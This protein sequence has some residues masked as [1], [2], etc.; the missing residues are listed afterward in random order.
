[1]KHFFKVSNLTLCIDNHQENLDENISLLSS[2]YI[3]FPA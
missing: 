1:M 2:T 3:S